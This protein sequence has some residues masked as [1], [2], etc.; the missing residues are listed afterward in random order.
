MSKLRRLIIGSTTA[1][2]AALVFSGC[3]PSVPEAPASDNNALQSNG[4]DVPQ[5]GQQSG[6][7]ETTSETSAPN[8][9]NT[10]RKE[11][12]TGETQGEVLANDLSV[13]TEGNVMT[14]T[15]SFTGS[16]DI[17]WVVDSTDNPVTQG[18]GD[19]IDIAGPNWLDISI[20]GTTTPYDEAQQEMYYSGPTELEENG[21]RIYFDGTYEDST[22]LLVGMDGDYPWTVSYTQDPL[23]FNLLIQLPQ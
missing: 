4:V 22:H 1:F 6:F 20:L 9:F 3:T 7:D 14:V 13:T 19:P 12:P 5:S 17:G 18:K 16:G 11:R 21:V 23:T 8:S 15:V 2:L 10:L